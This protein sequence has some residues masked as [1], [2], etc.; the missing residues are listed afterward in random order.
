MFSQM[1]GARGD[2]TSKLCYRHRVSEAIE[3]PNSNRRA[4]A[5]DSP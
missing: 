3:Q 2:E 4:R 1:K 5:C